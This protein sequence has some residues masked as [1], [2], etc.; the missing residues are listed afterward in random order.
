MKGIVKAIILVIAAGAIASVFY[1]WGHRDATV[2]GLDREFSSIYAR[3]SLEIRLLELLQ[4]AENE[5]AMSALSAYIKSD[6]SSL[7]ETYALR[8]E[9]TIVSE[10]RSLLSG[11]ASGLP[12]MNKPSLNQISL[13]KE[14]FSRL[15]GDSISGER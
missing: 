14:R 15:D 12:V 7:E 13:L 1:A 5:R 2:A 9:V 10:V 8:G 3:T 4:E 6:L 11:T